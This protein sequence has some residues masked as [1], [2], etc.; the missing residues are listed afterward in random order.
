MRAFTHIYLERSNKNIYNKLL[1]LA[2]VHIV[3]TESY[4][5]RQSLN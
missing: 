5:R 3:E 4:I 1:F 2:K